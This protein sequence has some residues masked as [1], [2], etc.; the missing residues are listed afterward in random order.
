M[1]TGTEMESGGVALMRRLPIQ[2]ASAS[3][4]AIASGSKA[5]MMY[6]VEDAKHDIGVLLKEIE[7]LKTEARAAIESKAG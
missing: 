5:Q 1:S 6:F 4:N 3:P 2:Y 7:R